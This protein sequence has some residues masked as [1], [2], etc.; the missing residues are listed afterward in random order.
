MSS[1][2][3]S[4]YD[5]L[6]MSGEG[7]STE[8][9]KDSK[10]T[11]KRLVAA[12]K[13]QKWQLIFAFIF[14][15]GAVVLNLRAPLIF[16]D[17]INEIFAGIMPAV[18]GLGPIDIDFNVLGGFV[19]MLTIVYIISAI[20][21]YIQERIMASVAQRLVLSLRERIGE[22]L[23]KVP[24]KFFDTNKKGE[25]LSRVTNDLERVSEILQSAIMRLFTSAVTILGAIFLMFRINWILT[26]IAIGAII[27]GLIITAVVSMKSAGYFAAR[28]KSLGIF[29]TRIEEY[30]SGQVEIKSFTLEKE[31]VEKTESA[32]TQ[33]YENDKKAQFI[34]F[35]IMPIIRLFNQAGYVAI[36]GLGASFVINGTISIG[37]VM[38]F[39]QYVQMSQEPLTE[40]SFVL[41]SLQAAIAS[42]ERVFELM[43]EDEESNPENAA[44]AIEKPHG[45][46][47]FE[48]V[49]FGYGDD[50]L[51][52]DV[53][54]EALS[55]QKVAIVGP[56]GAGKTTLVNLLMRFYEIKGG[57]IKVD[58]VDIRQF[59]RHYLRSLFGMVLQDSWMFDGTVSENIAYG[60]HR[61][62]HSEIVEAAKIARA[63]YFIR[64]L[65]NGYDSIMNDENTTLSQGEQQL[66]C[67][68]RAILANPPMLLLDEAT[69]SVDTR[70]EI[71]IQKAM[72]TLMEGRTSFIIA[73]RLSTIRDADIILVMNDGDIVESGNHEDL[74]AKG[75][76][77]SEIYHSQ[78][79]S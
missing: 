17:A 27:V 71:H 33:L 76:M 16:A 56:T 58:G 66:I 47:S 44:N 13:P 36:A 63:D 15:T 3:S 75:G 53:C 6:D 1:D 70:T 22:K 46:I 4:G 34:M 52:K 12:L 26:L 48:N 45:S 10:K 54:F 9:A 72:D 64:T 74:L 30:F 59:D 73:H 2:N 29:N 50:L 21:T 24:L 39:F 49:Q 8:K 68:A 51:M 20:L 55:G 38:S 11:L 32:A 35:A 31:A 25:I 79:A 40:A 23:A 5:V 57:T 67:I 43:D 65:P 69:S 18:M 7:M 28:Q 37:Q 19:L 42:A 77:Y 14:A 62:S 41:N 60:R 78:F 61:A